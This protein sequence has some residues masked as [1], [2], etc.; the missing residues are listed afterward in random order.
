MFR[1]RRNTSLL[2]GALTMAE[3]VFHSVARSVRSKHNNAFL[4]L[5]QNML[6]VVVMVAAFYFMFQLFGIRTAP[7]RGDFVLFLLTGVFLFMTHVKAVGAVMGAE[8]PTSAMMLHA[9]MNTII[10]ISASALGIL[11]INILTVLLILF[12]YHAIFGAVEIQHPAGAFGML[13]LA[14]FTG[15]AVG[16]MFLSIKPWFPTT[17]GIMSTVYRRAQMIASGKMFVANAIP[18]S[19]LAVFD[20]N[21]LFH[22]IDQSRGFAFRNYFPHVTSWH[23]AL[24][25]GVV[26]I[27][28]G[29]M[30]E[31]YTRRHV[32]ASWYAKR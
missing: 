5:G 7:L 27:M 13:L 15:C 4:A 8:G 11:Y 2:S 1:Y 25:V 14:W 21:P 22:I 32:S 12:G 28:L 19:M 3:L 6:Q 23:Y 30:G 20:W 16:L 24:G 31:F 29:L 18:A 26:L 17:V 9:P 10:S